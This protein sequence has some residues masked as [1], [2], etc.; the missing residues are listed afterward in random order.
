MTM[1]A[2]EQTVSG[3]LGVLIS[4][5]NAAQLSKRELHQARIRILEAVGVTLA[6]AVEPVTRL[7]ADTL[8]ASETQGQALI[9][10]TSRRASALDATFVNATACAI[11]RDSGG[12]VAVDPLSAMLVPL[13]VAL[14]EERGAGGRA[15]ISAYIVGV[16][17]VSRLS[18]AA[19]ASGLDPEHAARLGILGAAAAASHLLALGPE[20][21]GAAL[22]IAASLAGDVS[23]SA[24][25]A[26]RALR[27]GR[28]ARDGLLAALLAERGSAASLA[29]GFPDII[30][31]AGLGDSAAILDRWADPLRII[32]V[33]P[34][35]DK[36][37]ADDPWEQFSV[38]AERALPR[39]NVAPLFERLET[40]DSVAD[41]SQLARL[42]EV[43]PLYSKPPERIVLVAAGSEEAPETTWV[44]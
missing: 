13:L 7:L 44:P 21:T 38:R 17:T 23:T 2:T 15:L 30:G 5:V 39:E 34:R 32:P 14:A 4:G 8:G 20:Q 12:G 3:R 42:L 36:Q 41:M 6:G 35:A 9:M 16:E 29:A 18:G 27:I 1:I 11:T 25:G 37:S 28:M 22:A 33:A 26:P 19:E 43:S 24:S 40:I 10:G 31:Q